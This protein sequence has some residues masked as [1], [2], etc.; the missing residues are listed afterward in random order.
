MSEI[1]YKRKICARP[2]KKPQDLAGVMRVS[3]DYLNSDI[4][5]WFQLS[6]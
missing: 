2:A 4:L 3:V 1:P 5:H 6:L